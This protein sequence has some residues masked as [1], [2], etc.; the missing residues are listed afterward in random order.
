M[1]NADITFFKAQKVSS[2][3]NSIEIN[4]INKFKGNLPNMIHNLILNTKIYPKLNQIQN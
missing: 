3:K 4:S 2:H 1:Y